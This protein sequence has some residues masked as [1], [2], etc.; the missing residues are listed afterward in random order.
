MNEK[1]SIPE[2]H[3]SANGIKL[4][5]CDIVFLR[6]QTQYERKVITTSF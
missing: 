1:A 6:G 4:I 3:K 5:L 2:C